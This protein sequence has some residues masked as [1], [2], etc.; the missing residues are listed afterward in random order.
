MQI[1]NLIRIGT[2]Q[3][4]ESCCLGTGKITFDSQPMNAIQKRELNEAIDATLGLLDTLI[5]QVA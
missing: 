5:R 3:G 4:V 1:G 2:E